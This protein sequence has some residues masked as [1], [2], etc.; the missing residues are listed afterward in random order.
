A[1]HIA[2][3]TDA[4]PVVLYPGDAWTV[5]DAHDN[6]ASIDRYEADAREPVTMTTPSRSLT[7]DE[8]TALAVDYVLRLRRRSNHMVAA[9]AL[10]HARFLPPVRVRLWDLE[11]TVEIRCDRGLR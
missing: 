4:E 11:R 2:T 5:G 1:A 8:L 6:D 9:R 3:S 10:E 7:L